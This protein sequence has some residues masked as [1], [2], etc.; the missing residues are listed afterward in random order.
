MI[1]AARLASMAFSSRVLM[2]MVLA[3]SLV[4]LPICS[5]TAAKVSEMTLARDTSC[6]SAS[7]TCSLIFWAIDSA[8]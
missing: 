5:P 6:A 8:L 7:E 1:S 4:L 2:P 3:A